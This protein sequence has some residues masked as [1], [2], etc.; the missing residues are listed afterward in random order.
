MSKV[1]FKQLICLVAILLLVV[2]LLFVN[3]VPISVKG[4]SQDP[5]VVPQNE[6]SS[7]AL[8]DEFSNVVSD[9]QESLDG[10][11][12]DWYWQDNNGEWNDYRNWIESYRA[13]AEGI[14]HYQTHYSN[15]K[16]S[17]LSIEEHVNG[18]RLHVKV[19][20]GSYNIITY[21]FDSGL[22]QALH[23]QGAEVS[24]TYGYPAIPFKNL[25]FSLP[26]GI[27]PVAFQIQRKQ[28]ETISG[29]SL[30]P[31]AAPLR[32]TSSHPTQ[33]ELYFD[34]SVYSDP[35]FFPT[36]FIT[37]R[38]V[39]MA[40]TIGVSVNLQFLQYNPVQKQSHLLVCIEFDV[41]LSAPVS[42]HDLNSNPYKSWL[43]GDGQ[44]YVVIAPAAFNS[45]LTD[46]VKWKQDLR[47]DVSVT[48]L[49]H[50]YATYPGRD[51][52]EQ[53]R[54]F[55]K[56]SY[57]DNGSLYFLLVGDCDIVPTREV[58]DP[59]LAGGLDNGT[60]PSDMY[61]E[62]LDGDW[63]ANGNDLFGETD[64]DVDFYSEVLVGR[65]PVQTVSEAQD[66]LSG[67]VQLE[68]N[69]VPGSWMNDFLLI[70][71][72]CFGS[73]DG[74]NMLEEELNQ[75]FLY[76]SFF[77][78]SRLYPTDGSLSNANV[79]SKINSGI[80]IIDFFDH[81]W[82]GGWSAALDE[83]NYGEVSGLLNG[84]KRPFTFAMACETAAFDAE[85]FEPTIGE[86]FFRNLNGGAVA[87]IG[88]TRIAWAG[89]HA[90]D[91]L[92]N[93]FWRDF[94]G[95]AL[96]ERIVSPKLSL[97]AALHEMITT[98]SM[99]DPISR[100]TIY[101][102][103]YFGDPTMQLYW[104]HNVTNTASQ[105]E[106]SQLVQL[107][108]TCSLLFNET[109]ISETV[110]VVV[111]DPI[112]RLVHNQTLV[113][114]SQGRYTITFMANE[115]AGN[116][117]VSTT[118]SQPFTHTTVN[119]FYVGNLSCAVSLDSSP[120]YH[121]L[122]DFSG[123]ANKDGVCN[124]S[125]I[126]SDGNILTSTLL[127][128]VGGT[129]SGALNITEFGWL[130]LFITVT[131]A[132]E[133]GGTHAIFQVTRGD[134]LVIADSNGGWGPDYPGGWADN[135]FGDSTNTADYLIALKEE[136]HVSIFRPRYDLVPTLTLLESFD[137][138]IVS[139]G[140]NYGSP[141]IGF[142][143]F[144]LDVLHSY[145][146]AGGNLLLEGC[147]I[148]AT[149]S[150]SP[151][152]L[153]LESFSHTTYQ[154][155]L[156]NT[157]SLTLD[158]QLHTITAG[159]PTTI[160]LLDGLGTP[161]AD[162]INPINGSER[163][164]SYLGESPP[165]SAITAL[166]STPSYGGFVYF[167]FS[168]DAIENQNYRNLIIQNAIA[169]LIQPRL[170]ASLSDDALQTGTT[171]TITIDV[172]EAATG[173]LINDA[174]VTFNGCGIS[175]SNLT[176][177]DGSC[178]ISITPT[179]EGF[180]QITITKAG[181][182]NFISIIIVYDIPMISIE[183]NPSFL[184]KYDSQE[185]TILATDYYEHF[186][187]D[188]CFINIT[189]CGVNNVGHTNSS[190]LGDFSVAPSY[191][192]IIS[193]YANLTGY[194]N[195]TSSIGVQ[196]EV[197]VLPSVGT[198]SPEYFCW[199]EINLNW[200]DYGGIPVFINYTA[201]PGTNSSFTLADI[202]AINPDTLILPHRYSPY[203]SSEIDAIITYTRA[204]HGLF[205]TSY[206]LY[207]HPT[208]LAPFFGLS[209]SLT[210]TSSSSVFQFDIIQS[211]HP[212]FNNL[213]DPFTHYFGMSTYP[214]GTAWDDSV[215]DG[216]AYL[217]LDSSGTNFGAILAHRGM[218]YTSHCPELLSNRDDTQLVYNALAWTQ[219]II[220][221]HDLRVVLDVPYFCKPDETI[222]IN[223]TVMNEGQNNETNLL[224][225]LFI[226]EIEVASLSIPELAN[227]TSQTL[228]YLWTPTIEALYNIS[229]YVAPVPNEY[230][231]VNNYQ[232]RLVN[233]VKGLVAILNADGSETP[234]YWMGG[235]GNNYSPIYSGLI[236]E[237]FPVILITNMDILSGILVSVDIVILIDNCPSNDASAL[238]RDWCLAGGAILTFDSSICFLNWAGI[239]P[240]EAAGSNGYHT[241]WDYNSPSSGV[242]VDDSHPIMTGYSYG[243]TIM[244][245]GGDAQYFSTVM[246][247]TSAG[248]YYSPLVKTAIGSDFD[249]IVAYEGG[250]S[251]AA[252]QIWDAHHW[253]TTTNQ[254][255]ISNAVAWLMVKPDHDLSAGLITPQRAVPGE[256]IPITA[257][258]RNR[259]L[260][261]ETNVT[262]QLFIEGVLVDELFI[263][264]LDEGEAQTISYDWTPLSEGSY[265]I[266]SYVVPVP[267]EYTLVNNIVTRFVQVSIIQGYVLWDYIHGTDSITSYS[268]W[269]S[270]L[271]DLGCEIDTISTGTITS[272]LLSNYNV[273]ICAQPTVSYT[274]SELTAIQSFVMNGGGLLVI[275]DNAHSIFT[276]L[277]QFAGID[278]EAGGISGTTTD[279]TPHPVTEGVVSAYFSSPVS[280][281]LVSGEA[282]S[283]IRNY[284]E[285]LL[286]SSE[287]GVGRVLGIADENT[288][289]DST[290][291]NANNRLL[292]INM[293]SWLAFRYPH[294]VLV[295]LDSP[296]YANP[297]EVIPLNMTV[298]NRGTENET[299]LTLQLF[300]NDS[301]TATFPISELNAGLFVK[302]NTT[303]VTTILGNYNIT[304]Y[305]IPVPSE[306]VTR[307]NRDTRILLIREIHAHVLYD[308]THE[309]QFP[310]NFTIL[311]EELFAIG[312]AIDILYSGP[313]DI[314]ILSG[315]DGFISVTPM[316]PYTPSE[317][318]AIQ[319]YV[320]TGGGLLVVGGWF[321]IICSSLTS[322]AGISFVYDWNGSI[323]DDITPHTITHGV[324]SLYFEFLGTTL[325]VT[326]PAI[327]LARTPTDSIVLAAY[328]AA[329][330]VI[331]FASVLAL[332]DYTVET[333]DN[334]RLGVNMVE[335]IIDENLAPTTPTLHA[336]DKT[337]TQPEFTSTWTESSDSDGF[338]VSYQLQLAE[339][340]V[341]TQILQ[342][343]TTPYT[344]QN[345]TVSSDGTYYLRVRSQDNE[346]RYSLWSNIVSV[347]VELENL[348]PSS[349]ILD[350][351]YNNDGSVTLSWS[352]ASD[353]DGYVAGYLLQQSRQ[354]SFLVVIG[355]WNVN[356]TTIIIANL[357]AGMNYFRV[358]AIDNE[359]AFSSWS[360][361]CEMLIPGI[362]SEI[363]LIA[364][365]IGIIAVV[366]SIIV[367][368]LR[369]RS[370]MNA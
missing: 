47:Y 319:T 86:A 159:L 147:Y 325:E 243:E 162:V 311:F 90:F 303:W 344:T 226:D 206:A 369:K 304:A 262:F 352:S 250:S 277:T 185:L 91:G 175:S 273:L 245:T 210:F 114:D 135:N 224:L 101:Q 23:I 45:A 217:A 327:D 105:G 10:P 358:A 117:T 265:N 287:A 79:I 218:V 73:G 240:P 97:H 58:W 290:I 281:L 4:A 180:I 356:G 62:C 157:G 72:D 252:V 266:T 368:W 286:A 153:T 161:Y 77:D 28:T 187:L 118:I 84:G 320:D 121:N 52:A 330:R 55:I 278:W 202:E 271:L 292:A 298:W 348:A 81:G 204:G 212:L 219:C 151:Y 20:V 208:S 137:V 57:T 150:N 308:M 365:A 237:G 341:F 329:G 315:Y 64:D 46:F 322:F 295:Q 124:A 61:F 24:N 119:S 324:G 5:F 334:L 143:S 49:D 364:I 332:T 37:F 181:Y 78:V 30:V 205:A 122:L 176:Q 160:P 236:T 248:P 244:G 343:H 302:I 288:I 126:T 340:D 172:H 128:I 235:W 346:Y 66:V 279:I 94:F 106:T 75:W 145:H 312:I 14:R 301:L 82:Y 141:L 256:L 337:I 231:I 366:S 179:S 158:N 203:T 200:Q 18:N 313:I 258:V 63:D 8:V 338:I 60:E 351:V 282:I 293:V 22:H 53:V 139:V 133:H 15:S 39:G 11:E 242:V 317:L 33:D 225:Q 110:N 257:I 280:R 152:N 71:P 88:A 353:A 183:T 305:V 48:T 131:N 2:P 299:A 263:P 300:I 43:N 193:I 196:I 362:P 310:S 201:F 370:Q 1:W 336:I 149:L 267:D 111:N 168:I 59:Y 171:E 307:N 67:I 232:E 251:G 254:L 233:V 297:G 296:S 146:N 148:S 197:L 222:N 291:S 272:T 253:Q 173:Q 144:L 80:G 247:G 213:P 154:R 166:T 17:G 69:P 191:S 214:V 165:G 56:A 331:G 38:E 125:I 184:R 163:V 113:T 309:N 326:S 198:A 249:L 194:I 284:G 230:D 355:N 36:D 349:P 156:A 164:S 68:S 367:L 92:H 363:I 189:G 360:N 44:G 318:Y 264:L 26:K 13:A 85:Y 51:L 342:I 274:S 95:T 321:P 255:L 41:I 42:L 241:Y 335:W 275:G 261:N 323:V 87:Y 188:N 76:D 116:Y 223:A 136:Y 350:I 276:S 132:S 109:P 199:D 238:L 361:C 123:T 229:A 12:R 190:G 102:A 211:G 29:L 209:Q 186:P 112:G 178:S 99:S 7:N 227:F 333:M 167:A 40:G 21:A 268:I 285:T 177:P 289:R 140:D 35:A 221:E 34:Q 357:P 103:I 104:K 354:S 9:F 74:A 127:P 155:T 314:S 306:N 207:F 294:D 316:L 328:E 54:N 138:V 283:L 359:G 19:V 246:Q 93:R 70:G 270:D 220:P 134:I 174:N 260:N 115:L 27:H 239:L 25:L 16:D 269:Q 192:G 216:A 182:L 170:E 169:Y 120:I 234:S 107:N 347:N 259:G 3:S 65:L 215:L 98:Y 339:D 108:G 83:E 6:R 50:I 142:D 96:T 228:S 345:L 100:E 130:Q 32:L 31:G 89:Y 129:Y 195:A